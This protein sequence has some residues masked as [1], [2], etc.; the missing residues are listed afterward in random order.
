MILVGLSAVWD[1]GGIAR[2]VFIVVCAAIV[3]STFF[4]DVMKSITDGL[5][6]QKTET[7]TSFITNFTM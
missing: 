2:L 1:K 7:A 5:G 6:I 3:I 4:P